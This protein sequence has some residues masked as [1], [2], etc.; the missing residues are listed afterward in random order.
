M[1]RPWGTGRVWTRR[2]AAEPG[3]GEAVQ[4]VLGG[5]FEGDLVAE[6]FELADVG[7]C[8]AL[9]VGAF[10]VEVRAQIGEVGLGVGQEMPDDH[11]DGAP[12]GDDGLVRAT[13]PGDAPVAFTQEGVGFPG[14]GRGFSQ[15][16]G[17]VAVAV[18]GAVLGLGFPRRIR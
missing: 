2:S 15:G 4:W 1:T 9:G 12:D 5:G 13:A 16:S 17:Q 11:E 6:G 18:P 7:L 14:G 8:A 3:R 10:V